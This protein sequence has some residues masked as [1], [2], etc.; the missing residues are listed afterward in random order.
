MH[1]EKIK[2]VL[3]LDNRHIYT[4]DEEEERPEDYGSDLIS[5]HKRK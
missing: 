2:E 5:T 4:G 1:E 3:N